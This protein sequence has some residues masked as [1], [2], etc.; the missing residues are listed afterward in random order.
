MNKPVSSMEMLSGRIPG[1][2][3]AWFASLKIDG[4][5][6]NSDKL[7]ILLA[8]LKRQHEGTLDYASAQAW[9]RDLIVRLRQDV[10][11]LEHETGTHSEALSSLLEHM[12]AMAATVISAH[13]HD[14]ESAKALEEQLIRRATAMAEGLLRQAL[15]PYAAT[16]D[17]EVVRRHSGN[18]VELARLI[19]STTEGG[20]HG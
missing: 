13:P 20:Q 5:V 11:T 10:A 2:L 9:M 18:L 1:E 14:L 8:Q 16:Y 7:R 4:A 17:P 19:P 12:T 6:T 15:T 3:Y